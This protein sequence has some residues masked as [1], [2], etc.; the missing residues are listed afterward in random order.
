MSIERLW[1]LFS[2]DYRANCLAWRRAASNPVIPAG[3]AA[4]KRHWTANPDSLDFGGRRLLYYRG[5]GYDERKPDVRHDRI[6]VAELRD[7]DL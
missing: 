5:N 4:W 1:D 7:D 3:Q 2:S 6:A